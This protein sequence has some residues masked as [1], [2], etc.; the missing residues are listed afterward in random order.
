MFYNIC[1]EEDV[2]HLI[3][4][5]IRYVK[6]Q[7]AENLT[8]EHRNSFTSSQNYVDLD[9]TQ[10]SVDTEFI[11]E[12]N[13]DSEGGVQS[14]GMGECE[15]IDSQDKL[16]LWK[17]EHIPHASITLTEGQVLEEFML[18]EKIE[19]QGIDKHKMVEKGI[20]RET[21]E[22]PEMSVRI[23]YEQ[24]ECMEEEIYNRS[25]PKL[26]KMYRAEK[27]VHKDGKKLE[28]PKINAVEIHELPK[29]IK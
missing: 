2:D 21:V 4:E 12:D 6:S 9:L 3:A 5:R 15:I 8:K 1:S 19:L 27:S 7:K 29:E 13:S 11:E 18:G 17:P 20:D 26:P 16:D 22:S 10:D 23:A 24:E 25:I 28:I 14:M